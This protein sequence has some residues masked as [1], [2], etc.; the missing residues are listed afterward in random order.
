MYVEADASFKCTRVTPLQVDEDIGDTAAIHQF[1]VNSARGELELPA[2]VA[3]PWAAIVVERSTGRVSFGRDCG[4]RR[5]LLIHFPNARCPSLIIAST[6]LATSTSADPSDLRV[7]PEDWLELPPMGT[8]QLSLA[9]ETP[10]SSE[11]D[12]LNVLPSTQN[13]ANT[14]VQW[15]AA[16][17]SAPLRLLPHR[18]DDPIPRWT[19]PAHLTA[20]EVDGTAASDEMPSDT[21]ASVLESSAASPTAVPVSPTAVPVSPDWEVLATAGVLLQLMSQAVSRR[22]RSI[23][24][25]PAAS[26]GIVTTPAA[27]VPAHNE[28]G[29]AVVP[30]PP[31]SGLPRM[32]SWLPNTVV[33]VTASSTSS[34][35]STA[36]VAV[37]FSGGLDSMVL[38]A[39]AHYHCPPGE[40]ID[41]INV[42]FDKGH[43]S[44][45]RQA[46]SA[47]LQELRLAYPT[48]AWQLISVDSSYEQ[49]LETQA[50]VMDLLLPCDTHM[51]FNIGS[52]LWYAARGVGFVKPQDY[53]A[54][55]TDAPKQPVATPAPGVAV[56]PAGTSTEQ[57]PT[58]FATDIPVGTDAGAVRTKKPR[59][60]RGSRRTK[61]GT[62]GPSGDG[63]HLKVAK[64]DPS[65]VLPLS[66]GAARLYP[67]LTELCP[68]ST[69]MVERLACGSVS[70][71][72]VGL[73]GSD[74][75]G[76]TGSIHASPDTATPIPSSPL[77][78]LQER[79][80]LLGAPI[81]D[82]PAACCAHIHNA[83]LQH[84]QTQWYRV[85]EPVSHTDV[86]EVEFRSL[87][88]EALSTNSSTVPG[89]PTTPS[90]SQPSMAPIAPSAAPSSAAPVLVRSA[91]KVLL[92]GIGAD[93]QMAG[94]GRHRSAFLAGGWSRLEA[95]LQQDVARLWKRNLGRDDRVC[96]DHGRETR[97]PYLDEDVMAFLRAVPLPVVRGLGDVG[98]EWRVG[99][100]S[101]S[102]WFHPLCIKYGSTDDCN[103]LIFCFVYLCALTAALQVT[104][105]RK[106]RG[107]GDKQ[108]LRVAARMLGL[109][110]SSRLVK[111]AI[112]FGS[113]IAKQSNIHC[114]GSNRAANKKNTGAASYQA[115]APGGEVDTEAAAAPS[116]TPEVFPEE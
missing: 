62:L 30:L 110:Q 5:S 86:E 44:P 91:A 73:P 74:I 116:T 40:C 33:E 80:H 101:P 103:T 67:Q 23:P 60:K 35:I 69:S 96:S 27:H 36:A 114:F 72:E 11:T 81:V 29:K 93:E 71:C 88:R 24:R 28:S 97:F 94:Y 89:E 82:E 4:G 98:I 25:E 18:P 75:T 68:E 100:C 20:P 49:V 61:G 3:G 107:I 65:E 112:Q 9:S 47:G 38:A 13:A 31:P 1:M 76:T 58:T 50:A 59:K 16:G 10:S 84:L 102:S 53:P 95:E 63:N 8:F 99:G 87:S 14:V 15:S 105:P 39:L 83:M 56:Q 78:R 21:G 45:D 48:R 34:P 52:A 46:A 43:R 108:I 106:D 109:T 70:T 17:R 22:V 2:A 79:I 77:E 42:C 26:P 92:L 115:T 32:A 41:L 55:P 90:P 64:T 7:R 104:D 37:L 12:T 57:A 54:A 19:M 66:C 6:A 85:L 113:R 111:R 51:D